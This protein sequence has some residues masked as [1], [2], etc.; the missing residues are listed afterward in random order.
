[1]I[2]K[3]KRSCKIQVVAQKVWLDLRN[4]EKYE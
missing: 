4:V 1:M 2:T 3:R